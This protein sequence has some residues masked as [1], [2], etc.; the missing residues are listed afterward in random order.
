MEKLP[1]QIPLCR[2][3]LSQALSSWGTYQHVLEIFLFF[4]LFS[5][6]C[7]TTKL[8]FSVYENEFIMNSSTESNL[9]I[10]PHG[11]ISNATLHFNIWFKS[12]KNSKT[13]VINGTL[14]LFAQCINWT[15]ILL[16]MN[17]KCYVQCI[18]FIFPTRICAAAL[19]TAPSTLH[20]QAG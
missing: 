8:L 19:W 1:Y 7:P 2:P 3:V 15:L 11:L 6:K 17:T 20:P 16:I 12:C 9:E 18:H 14:L 13:S 10:V 4:Y 5:M